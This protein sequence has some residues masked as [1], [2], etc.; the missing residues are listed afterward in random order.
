MST[1]IKFIL[2]ILL[3]F[4]TNSADAFVLAP[5]ECRFAQLKI[6]ATQGRLEY[7]VLYGTVQLSDYDDFKEVADSLKPDQSFPTVY[8]QSLGGSLD[9]AYLI[10]RLFRNHAVT[11]RSGNPITGD[12]YSRCASS[13]AIIAAGAV[14]RYLVNIGL[15]SPALYDEDDKQLDFPE[16]E[17]A[18]LEQYLKEMQIDPRFY[19]MLRA[20]QNDKI[21]NLT[22]N[23]HRIG[24]SQYIVQFGFYQGETAAEDVDLPSPVRYTHF[25]YDRA[26]VVFAAMNGSRGALRRLVDEYTY[27]TDKIQPDAERAR[28]WLEIGAEQDD[29]AS[30]HDLG[31]LHVKAHD[32]ALAVPYFKRG[33]ELGFAGSQNNYGWHLYKGTGVKRNRSEAVYWIVRAAE[34]GEPFA[35]GSLCEIYSAGDVLVPNSIEA[36]KWCR[37]AADHMPLGK[38]RDTAVNI[39]DRF[40]G[41]MSDAEVKQANQRVDAWRPLKQE[42]NLMRDK[43]ATDKPALRRYF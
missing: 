26:S 29:I 41:R 6:C 37:L 23:P 39:M 2:P 21:L 12:Q 18:D 5:K 7:L 38:A 32:D 42:R 28:I 11:V 20:T 25:L 16:D 40:A 9:A 13:C 22:Y 1:L 35:Y 10:G 43:D 34:Q 3:L 33:A 30:L 36:M 19:M 17:Y 27:G 31:V 8:M 15:H 14:K 4:I 24:A